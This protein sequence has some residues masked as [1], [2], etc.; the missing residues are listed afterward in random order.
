MYT[1]SE[2][3]LLTKVYFLLLNKTWL[4]TVACLIALSDGA[5]T[6]GKARC[7]QGVC[8]MKRPVPLPVRIT[9]NRAAETLAFGLLL[10]TAI[11]S[12]E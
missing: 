11:P 5:I 4:A 2:G 6:V 3:I 10:A 8:V 7:S 12:K 1:L 9:F